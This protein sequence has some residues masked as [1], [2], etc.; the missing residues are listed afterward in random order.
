MADDELK[1]FLK[2]IKGKSSQGG[3]RSVDEWDS[4][5]K[6]IHA[7]EKETSAINREARDE[8]TTELYKKYKDHFKEHNDF[9][10]NYK[11]ELYKLCVRLLVLLTLGIIAC[12]LTVIIKGDL[13]LAEILSVIITASVTYVSSIV[14]ILTIIAKHLFPL[15]EEQ[16]V[17]DIVKSIIDADLKS[18]EIDRLEEDKHE[19]IK[20]NEDKKIENDDK[21]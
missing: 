20:R 11:I 17:N 5:I 4:Y 12:I 19:R 10:H 16:Y 21:D 13:S 2:R 18:K 8:I 6:G 15:N 3:N 14:S 1:K 9:K 7:K